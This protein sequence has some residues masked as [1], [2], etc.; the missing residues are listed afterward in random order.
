MLYQLVTSAL[1]VMYAQYCKAVIL[2]LLYWASEKQ[3][4]FEKPLFLGYEDDTVVLPGMGGG[5]S[6]LSSQWYWVVLF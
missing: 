4:R 5:R 6:N 3:T 2:A 1:P